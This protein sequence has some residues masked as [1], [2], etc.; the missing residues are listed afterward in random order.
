VAWDN[1]RSLVLIPGTDLFEVTG[2]TDLTEDCFGCP[3]CGNRA[4][5]L[6]EWDEDYMQVTCAICRT[7]YTP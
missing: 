7:T 1:R 3:E 4:M 2:D 5:D 6:L